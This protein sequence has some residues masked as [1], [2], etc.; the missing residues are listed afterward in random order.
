VLDAGNLSGDV[1]RRVAS[2]LE[3]GIPLV[4]E[5]FAMIADALGVPAESVMMA[6]RRARDSGLMR[7]FGA[8]WDFRAAGLEGYLFGVRAPDG[9]LGEVVRWINAFGFVTHNYLRR[10]ELNIWFTAILP[11]DVEAVRLADELLARGFEYI[12]LRAERRIKLETAFARDEG[13]SQDREA[14]EALSRAPQG[15]DSLQKKIIALLRDD[16]DILPCPFTRMAN[17]LRIDED[18][19]LEELVKL[20]SSGALRRIGASIDHRRAGFSANSLMALEFT[21]SEMD[22][23]GVAS[24]LPWVSHCYLRRPVAQNQ[25]VPWTYNMFTMIHARGSEELGRRERL[26][27]GVFAPRGY[28]SM[29]TEVEYKKIHFSFENYSPGGI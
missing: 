18:A 8:F 20:K 12:A 15:F 28:V 11:G 26:L 29:R 17:V 25:L 19:L 23:C 9:A 3:K 2:V 7:R 5:P 4:R 27:A 24:A 21:G 14:S 6:A 10:H 13:E 16:L 1:E 22:V